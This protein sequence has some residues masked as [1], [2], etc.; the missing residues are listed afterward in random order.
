MKH[1][2]WKLTLLAGGLALSSAALADQQGT[3]NTRG[4]MLGNTCAGCHGTNGSS[5][6][7][8][9]PTIAEMSKDTFTDAM[10]A[11]R[12]GKRYATVMT[13]IAKGYTDEDIAAMADFFSGQKFIRHEQEV[14]AARVARGAKLHEEHCDK[15]HEDSGRKDIDGSSI[16]GGQ[17]L[18]YLRFAMADFKADAR[19]MPK[20]MAKQVE[21]VAEKGPDAM[22]DLLHFYASQK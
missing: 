9:M 18:Q 3:F 7:L 14:D 2:L 21:N 15:C 8:S 6:G 20:K 12:D 10:K 19:E 11:F 5:A 17:W 16:L 4:A 1:Q 22:E 13:R